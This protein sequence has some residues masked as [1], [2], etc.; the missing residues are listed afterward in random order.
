VFFLLRSRLNSIGKA[1][2]A[3]SK[4]VRLLKMKFSNRA[5]IIYTM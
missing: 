3:N 5:R 1:R 4:V 2:K